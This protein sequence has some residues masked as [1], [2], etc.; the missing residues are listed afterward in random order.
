M[1]QPLDQMPQILN[2]NRHD[3]SSAKNKTCINIF[4]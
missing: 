3:F 2:F 4:I 1:L